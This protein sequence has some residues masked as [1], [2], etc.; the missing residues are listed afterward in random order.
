[1]IEN[2][3]GSLLGVGMLVYVAICIVLEPVCS[4]PYQ[5]GQ[6]FDLRGGSTV[7]EVNES[8]KV[9][10][11]RTNSADSTYFYEPYSKL[12]LK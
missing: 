10:W 8:E 2:I 4:N 11:F 5:K 1:M 9:V 3:F 7:I 12:G 6:H